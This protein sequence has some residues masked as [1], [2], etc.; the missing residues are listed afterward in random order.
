MSILL[1]HDVANVMFIVQP[2][3]DVTRALILA[4]GVCY[5][6]CLEKRNEYRECVAPLFT[7]PFEHVTPDQIFDEINTYDGF[8]AFFHT[9]WFEQSFTSYK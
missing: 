7:A 5:H 4:L 1:L 2:L 9:S 8:P 3:N 6:A